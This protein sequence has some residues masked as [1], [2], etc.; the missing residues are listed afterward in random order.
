MVNRMHP[1]AENVF[2]I[3]Y[4][5]LFLKSFSLPRSATNEFV[6]LFKD[7]ENLFRFNVDEEIV[8][9]KSVPMQGGETTSTHRLRKK[10]ISEV[11]KWTHLPPDP[12]HQL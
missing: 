12:S 8:L 4:V 5:A 6:Y 3:N 7:V 10:A 11:T 9:I 1:V 2:I